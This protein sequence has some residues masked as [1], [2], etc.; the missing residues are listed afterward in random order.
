MKGKVLSGECNLLS[1]VSSQQ[2]FEAMDIKALGTSQLLDRP[3]YSSQI[4]VTAPCYSS[5]FLESTSSRHEGMM[6]QRHKEERESTRARRR[7][8]A[9]WL[10]FLCFFLP[11]PTRPALCKLGQPGVLFVLP[12]VLTLVLRP[13]FVLFLQAFPFLVF[14]PP[15]FWTPVS[16]ST[17]L[18]KPLNLFSHEVIIGFRVSLE[19]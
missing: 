5:A 8:L 9:L 2:R 15:P 1:S 3:C 14:Q 7:D 17:Y 16:Q 19:M 18:T 12:E 10:L 13:S 11:P 4:S 6:T